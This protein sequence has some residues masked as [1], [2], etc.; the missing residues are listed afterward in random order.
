MLIF[1]CYMI[2]LPI[3]VYVDIMPI[4]IVISSCYFIMAQLITIQ[5][6]PDLNSVIE[7]S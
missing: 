5:V 6:K 1:I 4:W 7:L 3:H 2:L